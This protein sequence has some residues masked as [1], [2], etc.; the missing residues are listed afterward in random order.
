M[1]TWDNYYRATLK[2]HPSYHSEII[3]C[4]QRFAGI[5]GKVILEVG[6]GRGEDSFRLATSSA[7]VCILD[8]SQTAIEL[9]TN[10][11]R[12]YGLAVHLVQADAICLP[13]KRGSFDI[14]FHQGLLE[15]FREPGKIISEQKEVLKNNGYILVDVPQRYNL[16]TLKKNI[17]MILGLWFAGWERSFTL[18]GLKKLLEDNGFEIIGFYQRDY[19]PDI[20]RKIK[21][22]KKIEEKIFKCKIAPGR[23]WLI[24]RNLWENFEKMRLSRII[25][26]SIGVMARKIQA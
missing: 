5:Q 6:A 16:W 21:N 26:K 1:N 15:H 13:F 3:E 17:L 19:Y 20:I 9:L 2:K 18:G 4:I 10:K 11:K 23:L 22:L 12:L 24:Y 14:I 8:S 25:F 7:W